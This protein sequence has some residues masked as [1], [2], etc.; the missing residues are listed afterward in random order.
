MS[1]NEFT[2]ELRKDGA[3]KR[4]GF[5]S[6]RGIDVPNELTVDR[7]AGLPFFVVGSVAHAEKSRSV[8]SVFR[9]VAHVLSAGGLSKVGESVIRSA[10]IAVVDFLHRPFS[11]LKQPSEPVSTIKLV[12]QTNHEIAIGAEVSGYLA[13]PSRIPFFRHGGAMTPAKN[14]SLRIVFQSL[15]RLFK[16]EI[17]LYPNRHQRLPICGLTTSYVAGF[18]IPA[19]IS[20]DY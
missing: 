18:G 14:A 9:S 4:I 20:G 6:G 2:M 5:L 11:G 13:A 7:D 15:A 17:G 12:V 8:I 16:G 19:T 1:T 3:T 10:A